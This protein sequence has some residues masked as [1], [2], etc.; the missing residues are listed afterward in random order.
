MTGELTTDILAAGVSIGALI[1]NLATL[2]ISRSLVLSAEEVAKRSELVRTH[3]LKAVDAVLVSIAPMISSFGSLIFLERHGIGIDF[4]Q[5]E[6]QKQIKTIGEERSKILTL[7]ITS[8]PYL[9][10]ELLNIVKDILSKTE[11]VNFN[12]IRAI[13]SE[14]QEFVSKLSKYARSKYLA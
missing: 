10:D 6:I 11:S 14:L 4:T 13:E 9:T 8:A 12:E 1:W 3:A 7:S 2:K 5:P